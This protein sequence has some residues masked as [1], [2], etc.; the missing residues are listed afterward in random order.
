M[1]R[2]NQ[3]K[4]TNRFFYLVFLDAALSQAPRTKENVIL[5]LCSYECP[6]CESSFNGSQLAKMKKSISHMSLT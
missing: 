3:H 6:R 2:C 5:Q 4:G 1:L